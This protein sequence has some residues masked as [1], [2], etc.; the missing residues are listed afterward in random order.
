MKQPTKWETDKMLDVFKGELFIHP[1]A[2]D[3]SGNLCS[4][5][6]AYCFASMRS[7]DRRASVKKLIDLCLGKASGR[8][9]ADWLFN[10]GYPVCV[11]NRSDPFATSNEDN[12]PQILQALD[13]SPNGVFIQTKGGRNDMKMLD[14]VKKRNVVVYITIDTMD[15]AISRRVEPG[16]MSPRHRV[17]LA[18]YAKSRGWEVIIGLNPLVAEWMPEKSII[19]LEDE[20]AAAGIDRYLA[21]PLSLNTKDVNGMSEARRSMF[22]PSV[23]SDATG[24]GGAWQHWISQYW[25]MNKKGLHVYSV[26][27]CL[28]CHMDDLACAK[29]GKHM[30]SVQHFVDFAWDENKRSGK[31]VFTFRDFLKVMTAGNPEM[32][33]YE[34]RNIYKYILCV[35]R[36]I[37]KEG[38]I[39]KAASKYSDVYRVLWNDRRMVHSPRNIW[40]FTVIIDADGKPVRDYYGDIQLAFVGGGQIGYKDRKATMTADD[41]DGK[42]VKIHDELDRNV[43]A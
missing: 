18:K 38:G 26:N 36:A 10:K 30:N 42:G 25:R 34:N 27:G 22:E 24:H 17:E 33:E 31:L 19:A 39:A 23:V 43:C 37:W 40:C 32:L 21:M 8:A 41:L 35:N 6:C 12:T 15:E 2:L 11:S 1:A 7:Q 28:P 14:A 5:A 16:A 29:L 20:L 13:L 3:Y 9:L 4:N